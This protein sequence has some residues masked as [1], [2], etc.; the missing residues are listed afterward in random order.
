MNTLNSLNP[1]DD[2]EAQFYSFIS[3]AICGNKHHTI[4]RHT[5][6]LSFHEQSS[7]PPPLSSIWDLPIYP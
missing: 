6:F 3:T 4:I 2:P 7:N 1:L 5:V